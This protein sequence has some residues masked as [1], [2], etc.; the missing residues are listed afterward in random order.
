M[1]AIYGGI[2]FDVFEAVCGAQGNFGFHWR[3]WWDLAPDDVTADCCGATV[4]GFSGHLQVC[5]RYVGHRGDH[6]AA[7]VGGYLLDRWAN[8]TTV[9]DS[10]G[11][12]QLDERTDNTPL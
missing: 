5:T 1:T 2:E 9:Q 12:V 7:H 11:H 6:V 8:R 4:T 10:V 3:Y